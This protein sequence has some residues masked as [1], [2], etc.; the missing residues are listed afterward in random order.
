MTSKLGPFRDRT[1]WN[2]TKDV[3]R[4]C[5]CRRHRIDVAFR[6]WGYYALESGKKEQGS[7][8]S[9]DILYSSSYFFV[10]IPIP[11]E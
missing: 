1:T 5:T 2:L 3:T 6:S 9:V 8:C 7:A 10:S 11:L 4:T